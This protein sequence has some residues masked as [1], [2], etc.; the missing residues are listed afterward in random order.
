M[1]VLTEERQ[2]KILGLLRE[3]GILKTRDL[4]SLF[5]VSESTIRRDLQEMEEAGWLHRVHGGAT[6][7][8]K[9]ETELSMIEKSSKNIHEKK[10]I[11]KYAASL[12]MPGEFIYLDA[13]TT[14]YEM[15]PYLKGKNCHVITNSVDHASASIDLGLQTTML[16]GSIRLTTKAAVSSQTI[17]QI[18]R[19]HFDKAFIG[20][21]GI[22]ERYG[23]TTA[24]SEEAAT[25]KVAMGQAQHVFILADKTKFNKVNFSNMGNL[26]EAI[27]ITNKIDLD[28]SQEIKNQTIIKEVGK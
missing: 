6:K 25:K 19:C 11:A 14:T 4:M 16:G 27:V 1:K 26:D 24:D 2:K 13:G 10:E 12:V 15:L 5:D 7:I 8:I 23:Y 18:K 20:T 28:I 21:N 17:E 22:H 9:L 3:K